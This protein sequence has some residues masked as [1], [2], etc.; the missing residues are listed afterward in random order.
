MTTEHIQ[1]IQNAV[2]LQRA[3]RLAEAAKIYSRVLRRAPDNFDCVYLLATLHAQ[4]G[5]LSKAIELFRRA[6]KLRPD[7]LDVQ[8]NLAVALSMS[9]DHREAAHA[10]RRILD[11]DPRHSQARN[12]YAA[13]LL[14]DNQLTEA[15]QQYDALIASH[16][17]HADAYN[18]RGMAL[19]Y[20]KRLDEALRNYDKAIALRP[21]FPQAHVNRGNVL[22]ML[23]R[24]DEALASF[25]KAIALQPDFADAYSNAGNIY[26]TRRSYGE[27]RGAYDRA[28]AL[29]PDD[30]ETQSMRL[31]AKMYLCDWS[32]FNAECRS[33][34]DAVNAKLPVYPFSILPVST[35][36]AEQYRCATIFTKTRYPAA[37]SSPRP[38]AIHQHDR[39]RIAYV[40][41]DFR[42][43]AVSNLTAGLF[44]R[45]DKTLF[46]VTAISIG[47][48]DGSAL[49]RRLQ[50]A[51]D[52]FID[53]GALRDDDIAARIKDAEVDILIDL[54]GYTQGARMGIFTQR[55]APIQVG[56]LGY[57][58]TVG[59]DYIDYVVADATV[60]PERDF[61]F[62]SEKVVWLPGSFMVNDA[63]RPIAERTPTRAELQLPDGAFVFCCFNQ[64]YKIGPKI[65]DV[66][67]RLLRAIDGSV[68]WLKES[69]AEAARNLR[70]EAEQRGV[71]PE[72]LIFAPSVPL[73]AEHLARHRQADLFLDTL[74]YN[75]H[76]TTADALWA[77]LPVVTCLGETFAGR[78][79]ASLLKAAGLEELITTS[80]DDYA[81][82]A[83]KLARDPALLA[84]FKARLSRNRATCSLF[85]TAQFTRRIEAAYTRMWQMRQRG[86]R[87]MS[88]AVQ[89][90]D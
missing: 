3:G 48:D 61:G 27:A 50:G 35:A 28:L 42:E 40:S 76:A 6:A 58:G 5:D 25:E 73:A 69:G 52:E 89:A 82:L 74:P 4:Q 17:D 90:D 65:F 55:P 86:E 18:N 29:R 72:R 70:R 33:L 13:C 24:P 36:P 1:Q 63:A 64:P 22:A 66:W 38:G 60:I 59:A 51:F 80:L 56:Y 21:N 49:R 75:A 14:S 41:A 2:A 84:A 34:L 9:G 45:H 43:H 81:A 79:A 37:A 15:L 44:E 83:L 11:K 30:S 47:P 46:N 53:A 32:N 62:F 68:L 78:V 31:L 77:G 10:Y 85:D 67:M 16:P 57:S 39:L 23:H 20:L 71:A 54:N 87:P 26:S 88:F 8:Y 7:V 12:N 19:Q